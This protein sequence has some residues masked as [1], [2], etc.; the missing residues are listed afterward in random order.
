[1]KVV[2]LLASS[3]VVLLTACIAGKPKSIKKK[4][5]GSWVCTHSETDYHKR[6]FQLLFYKDDTFYWYLKDWKPKPYARGT[7]KI[8]D[9]SN[10]NLKFNDNGEQLTFIIK[11]LK[12]RVLEIEY[13]GH[14]ITFKRIVAL[15]TLP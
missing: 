6:S 5:V 10:V 13:N 12:H 4:L 1:M 8:D 15:K 9:S 14:L 2:T 3:L 7:F 11:T